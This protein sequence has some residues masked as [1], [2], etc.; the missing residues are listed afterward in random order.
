MIFCSCFIVKW[1]RPHKITGNSQL[2]TLNSQLLILNFQLF[3]KLPLF[4]HTHSHHKMRH[5]SIVFLQNLV[6]MIMTEFEKSRDLSLCN[7]HGNFFH[8]WFCHKFS[9]CNDGFASIG[10]GF[11]E[12]ANSQQSPSKIPRYHQQYIFEFSASESIFHR[13]WGGPR[14]FSIIICIDSL[15]FHTPIAKQILLRPHTYTVGSTVVRRLMMEFLYLLERI[16]SFRFALYT[17]N[18]PNKSWSL[19]LWDFDTYWWLNGCIS[20]HNQK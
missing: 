12:S 13:I 4:L 1:M 2:S 17:K 11:Y 16:F 5:I 7:G 19:D 9:L 14:R 20:K 10:I 6:L 8:E 3:K 15:T 18:M